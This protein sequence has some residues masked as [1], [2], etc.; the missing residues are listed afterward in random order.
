MCVNGPIGHHNEVRWITAPSTATIWVMTLSL[1][2]AV[3][4]PAPSS[5]PR[6]TRTAWSSPI[7]TSELWE[8]WLLLMLHNIC[9]SHGHCSWTE[10]SITKLWMMDWIISSGWVGVLC[11]QLRTIISFGIPHTNFGTLPSML[12]VLLLRCTSESKYFHPASPSLATHLKS[13]PTVLC[14][15]SPMSILQVVMIPQSMSPHVVHAIITF[16]IYSIPNLSQDKQT[17]YSNY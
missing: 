6:S 12:L 11:V 15:I 17:Q 14:S 3:W 10:H 13:P 7:A 9:L 4:V 8:T 2:P 1:F 5:N 16:Y